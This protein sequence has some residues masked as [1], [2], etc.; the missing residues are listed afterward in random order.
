[1]YLNYRVSNQSAG[2]AVARVAGAAPFWLEPEP[3]F[4]SGSY[5]Y[6]Y[7]TVNILF[8]WDPKYDFPLLELFKTLISES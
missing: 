7:S 1:M 5:Y 2:I 3:F 8:L 4:W 6:S